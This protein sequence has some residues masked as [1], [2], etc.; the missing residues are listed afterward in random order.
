MRKDDGAPDTGTKVGHAK[1]LNRA[2][3]GDILR[4]ICHCLGLV[5]APLWRFTTGPWI[6]QRTLVL[7]M[8]EGTTGTAA[9]NY[10]INH[11]G[12]R[13]VVLVYEFTM[14]GSGSSIQ[15]PGSRVQ[16]E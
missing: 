8:D 11:L 10:M 7:N 16:G 1:K 4:A 3:A 15:G 5:G 12:L 14:Q 2:A 9:V 6:Y 13:Q